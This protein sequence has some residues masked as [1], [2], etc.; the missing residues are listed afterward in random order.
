MWS[1]WLVFCDYGFSVSALWS[2]LTTPTVLLVFLL[3]WTWGISSWLVQQSTAPAP[4]LGRGVSPQGHPSWPWT[5]SSSSWPSCACVPAAPWTW[6]L[7]WVKWE[8]SYTTDS[9]LFP[10]PGYIIIYYLLLHCW[11]VM[12][13]PHFCGE[14]HSLCTICCLHQVITLR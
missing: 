1:Y 6:G 13:F 11:I 12:L 2:P 4:Y 9:L 7:G 3:L 5:W 10:I 8:W 14:Y